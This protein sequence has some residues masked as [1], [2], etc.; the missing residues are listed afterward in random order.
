MIDWA[1]VQE[2]HDEIGAEC[3]DEVID[4][5]LT[6]TAEVVARL[7]DNPDRSSLEV[8]LHFLKGGALNLGFTTVS[9]LCMQGEILASKGEGQGFDRFSLAQAY[10][11]ERQSFLTE[12]RVRLQLLRSAG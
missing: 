4:L 10:D 6:E 12:Y 9:D 3:F 8:D 7:C 5:F 2:L 1:R 11:Q